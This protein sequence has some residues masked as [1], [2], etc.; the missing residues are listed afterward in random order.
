MMV[1]EISSAQN[2]V[3][4]DTAFLHALIDEGVDTNGDS[5]ISPA[6]AEDVTHLDVSFEGIS[7]MTGVEAF[8]NLDTL[9]CGGNQLTNLDVSNN[10]LLIYLDCYKNQL[11]NLDVTK[12]IALIYLRSS[13]NQLVNLDITNNTNLEY[14]SCGLNS[15]TGLDV[16]NCT[17]LKTLSCEN[18]QISNLDITRHFDLNLLI[19][20]RN[21]L[22]SLDVANNTSLERI[23]C[24]YNSITNLDVS[25]CQALTRLT[26]S[27]NSLISLDISNNNLLQ[28]L[29][30]DEMPSLYE[31]CVWITPFPPNGLNINTFGS[32]NVYFTTDCKANSSVSIPDTAFL[33]ALIDE[34]VDTNGDSLISYDEAERIISLDV[35][36]KGITDMKGI[37]AFVNLDTLLLTGY[38]NYNWGG[39]PIFNSVSSL[40]VSSIL[41]LKYLDCGGNGMRNL[42]LSKNSALKFL[43][44]S[45]NCLTNLDISNNSDLE[46]LYCHSQ[47]YG[48]EFLTELDISQNPKLKRLLCIEN[49]IS[50]LDVSNNTSS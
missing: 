5:L 42:D 16:S 11:T 22:T 38:W 49:R 30:I 10:T 21:Q 8:I 18:N 12:N 15:L 4:S 48:W 35:S 23:Y 39:D 37:E 17:S 25:N 36:N 27:G 40:D 2:L 14:L 28:R 13:S 33:H 9:L 50:N 1:L 26:F 7:D 34:G 24:S 44:C 3:I 43:D 6:E 46:I 41:G 29:D 19:C 20:S 31:V 45:L 47:K 32:P